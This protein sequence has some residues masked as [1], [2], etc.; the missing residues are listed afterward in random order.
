MTDE[1]RTIDPINICC[2]C[3]L[4]IALTE[5]REVSPIREGVAWHF[6]PLRCI[7]LLLAELRAVRARTEAKK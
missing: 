4:A 3:G 1:S 6:D 5:T 2:R 7:E